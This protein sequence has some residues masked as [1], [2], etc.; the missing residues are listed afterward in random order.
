MNTH[1]TFNPEVL[2]LLIGFIIP[3]AVALITKRFADSLWKALTLI[4]LAAVAAVLQQVFQNGGD[5][6]LWPTVILF[7]QL[8]A[9]A[10]ISHFGVLQPMHITSSGGV[11]QLAVPGGIGSQHDTRNYDEPR[12]S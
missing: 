7:L 2:T 1:V 12:A 9:T 6:D 5:F 3:M 10:I 4:V 11:I 8:V